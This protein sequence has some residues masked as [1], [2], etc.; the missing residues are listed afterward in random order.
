MRWCSSGRP[1]WAPRVPG[2]LLRPSLPIP[3]QPNALGSHRRMDRNTG[4]VRSSAELAPFQTARQN[5]RG[6]RR[7]PTHSRCN[8][9]DRRSHSIRGTRDIHRCRPF[10]SRCRQHIL[11]RS[12]D[13][14]ARPTPVLSRRSAKCQPRQERLKSQTTIS[15]SSFP[16]FASKYPHP[17]FPDNHAA[18]LLDPAPP[19]VTAAGRR[20]TVRIISATVDRPGCPVFKPCGLDSLSTMHRFCR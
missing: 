6:I 15:D 7:T 11:L 8:H 5:I 1:R 9:L 4:A 3:L 16:P 18:A 12:R 14:H 2:R 19:T 17:G 10:G 20:Q 13:N